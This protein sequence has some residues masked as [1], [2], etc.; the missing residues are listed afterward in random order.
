VLEVKKRSK[1]SRNSKGSKVRAGDAAFALSM[2]DMVG[3]I[4][5]DEDDAA[6]F[7]PLPRSVRRQQAK[8]RRKRGGDRQELLDE[9]PSNDEAFE[10]A[11]YSG[12]QTDDVRDFFLDDTLIEDDDDDAIE[13]EDAP[14]D[15]EIAIAPT[16]APT[17]ASAAAPA[18]TT[19]TSSS[20]TSSGSEAAQQQQSTTDDTAATTTTTTDRVS[21]TDQPT[22]AQSLPAPAGLSRTRPG[23]ERT[24][25][26]FITRDRGSSSTPS[27]DRTSSSLITRRTSERPQSKPPSLTRT[28]TSASLSRSGTSLSSSSSL[29]FRASATGEG[30]TAMQELQLQKEMKERME[31]IFNQRKE[32]VMKEMEQWMVRMQQMQGMPTVLAKVAVV[33]VPVLDALLMP[34]S[35]QVD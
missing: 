9:T 29:L 31:K 30:L 27:L 8:E 13:L 26:S 15:D 28:A 10:D 4:N 35:N 11:R 21:S 19:T 16:P 3:S 6:V 18:S 33:A 12:T 22:E 32:L 2:T 23:L 7:E 17:P 1:R 25:T 34:L 5:V 20:S 24:A 14:S